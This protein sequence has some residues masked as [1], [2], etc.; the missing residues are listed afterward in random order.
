MGGYP[1]FDEVNSTFLMTEISGFEEYCNERI[2]IFG[3]DDPYV[4]KI[5]ADKFADEIKAKKI[6]IK[7]GKHLNAEFGYTKLEKL[8][9]FL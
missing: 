3:D 2:C 5:S 9:E 1:E 7:G 4:C 6:I 8:L